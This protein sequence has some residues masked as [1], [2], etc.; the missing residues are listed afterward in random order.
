MAPKN[1]LRQNN[2]KGI[3]H[4]SCQGNYNWNTSIMLLGD[5]HGVAERSALGPRS[6]SGRR[7][8]RGEMLLL[9][10][11]GGY[12][13]GVRRTIKGTLPQ[14]GRRIYGLEVFPASLLLG[15]VHCQRCIKK[16]SIQNHKH[17]WWSSDKPNI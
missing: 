7:R 11:M 10:H 9:G 5:G 1:F 17:Y 13:Q 15:S 3:S 8:I 12:E 6:L 4:F 14:N 2:L 16:S